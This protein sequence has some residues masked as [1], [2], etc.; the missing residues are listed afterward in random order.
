MVGDGDV[1]GAGRV[2]LRVLRLGISPAIRSRDRRPPADHRDRSALGVLGAHLRVTAGARLAATPGLPGLPQAG[3]SDHAR[4]GL[5]RRVRAAQGVTWCG[6]ITY[7]RTGEGWLYLATVIDLFS[8][9][10]IGWS[11]AEHMRTS[12]VADALETAVATRGG[13]G[14]LDGVIFHSD[15]GCQ[16][17]S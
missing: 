7:L 16:Y 11:L 15:R 2:P 14:H 6:D 1:P 10:V 3:R 9:R 13:G 8:R 17:T 5:R 12:L 4:P